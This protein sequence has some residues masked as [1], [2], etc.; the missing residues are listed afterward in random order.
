M[1]C[2]IL[3]N[4]K[5]KTHVEKENTRRGLGGKGKKGRAGQSRKE[6]KRTRK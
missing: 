3:K 1:L 4:K 5:V 6:K 2:K